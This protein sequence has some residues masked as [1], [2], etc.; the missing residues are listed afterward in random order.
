MDLKTLAANVDGWLA[1]SR[2][3]ILAAMTA[4]VSVHTKTGRNDLVTNVDAA[5]QQF[6]V[7]AIRAAYPEAKIEGEEGTAARVD[8][9]SGLVFFVDPIDGTMNFVKQRAHFAVM[10]GVYEDGQ[11]V[12]GAILDVMRNELVTGGPTLSARLNGQPLPAPADP[13]LKDGLLGASGPMTIHNYLHLGDAALASSGARISGSAGMEFKAIVQG[14][15]VGYVSYLQPW[16]IAAGMAI[17]AGFGLV[18][19]RPDGGP[20]DLLAPGVVVAAMPQ[21]HAELLTRMQAK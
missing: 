20:I 12:Y 11:P 18:C 16:D 10:L 9:L 6:L 17:G 19:T 5:N 7:A 8:D 15:L 21:A 14:Q 1:A 2:T 3:Q 13:P 4:P